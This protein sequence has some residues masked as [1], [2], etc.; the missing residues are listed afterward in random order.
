MT[1]PW[2][3]Y[4][5]D[6]R[7]DD[8]S[9]DPAQEEAVRL[10]QDFYERLL[11]APRRRGGPGGWWGRLRGEKPEPEIGL[12]M[13]GGVGRGKKFFCWATFLAENIAPRGQAW[14]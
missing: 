14:R 12:Y 9:H 4:Q 10:L 3:R 7:R 1:T 5:A 13:W 2:Q 8:F 6:L 11:A